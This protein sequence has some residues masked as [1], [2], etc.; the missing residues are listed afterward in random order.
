MIE[1]ATPLVVAQ[2]ATPTISAGAL[3]LANVPSGGIMGGYT[4]YGW[5]KLYDCIYGGT[6]FAVILAAHQA[7]WRQ[8]PN[9]NG[10]PSW[11]GSLYLPIASQRIFFAELRYSRQ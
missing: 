8:R 1:L 11:S 2:G 10:Q 7:G 6:A 3:T 9:P 4:N 5:G